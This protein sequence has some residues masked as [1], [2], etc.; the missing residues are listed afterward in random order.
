[1]AKKHWYCTG[2]LNTACS[3]LVAMTN[4]VVDV[5]HW[6]LI[7]EN[8]RCKKCQNMFEDHD[9]FYIPEGFVWKIDNGAYYDFCEGDDANY[10]LIL[11]S[12]YTSE[13]YSRLNITY[14]KFTANY[15]QLSKRMQDINIYQGKYYWDRHVKNIS[16][17]QKKYVRQLYKIMYS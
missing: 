1:M 4:T 16:E 9:K 12:E 13:S 7:P 6:C 2:Q 15:K 8:D 17:K 10:G 14:L 11:K 5:N 3:R